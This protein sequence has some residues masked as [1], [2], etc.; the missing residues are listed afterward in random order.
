V[1]LVDE[2]MWGTIGQ[3]RDSGVVGTRA[4][5][6]AIGEKAAWGKVMRGAEI[7]SGHLDERV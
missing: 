5:W 6:G 1:W 7:L 4:N 2:G 3:R